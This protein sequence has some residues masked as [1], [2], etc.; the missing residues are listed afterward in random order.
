M[1]P[2]PP[3]DIEAPGLLSPPKS[4]WQ[5]LPVPESPDKHEEYFAKAIPSHHK[6]KLIGA[7]VRGKSH[8]HVGTNC[9]D[10]FEF[11]IAR[12]WTV[13]AVADGVGSRKLSR[14]G[15][16]EACR[17]AIKTLREDLPHITLSERTKRQDVG[18]RGTDGRF[19]DPDMDRVEQALF[20]AMD[21][22]YCAIEEARDARRDRQEYIALLGQN[23]EV[24]DFSTTLLLAV[25]NCFVL[26]NRSYD[27]IMSL[28]VGDG[29]IAAVNVDD[30]LVILARPDSGEFGGQV[31]PITHAKIRDDKEKR[32]RVFTTI[33]RLKVVML[34]TDGVAD[35]YFPEDPGMLRLYGDL[36]KEGIIGLAVHSHET[37]GQRLDQPVSAQEKLRRWLDSYHVKGS[38]DDRT[39]VVLYREEN[40]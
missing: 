23:P 33:Q 14:V 10:W 28:Q 37:G 30:K 24:S 39:L 4:S 18:G 6:L 21:A 40:L 29:M 38:F 15:A 1:A 34:V 36:V 22:A 16:K 5:E 26:E 12:D 35:D 9:D 17:S 13:M 20:R 2:L 3:A 32:Q 31:M 27:F 7:R 25:H 19:S 11:D 8:K